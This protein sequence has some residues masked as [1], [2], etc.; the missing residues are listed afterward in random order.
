METRRLSTELV[1]M[2]FIIFPLE[3]VQRLQPDSY[4]NTLQII[5][6]LPQMVSKEQT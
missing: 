4:K 2:V 3:G 6:I 1:M 5:R